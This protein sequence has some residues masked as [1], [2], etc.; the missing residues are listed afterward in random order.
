MPSSVGTRRGQTT[1]LVAAMV[2]VP[3]GHPR[4]SRADVG[5]GGG[6]AGFTCLPDTGVS[7]RPA[8]APQR[9][10]RRSPNDR[11]TTRWRHRGCRCRASICSRPRDCTRARS[12]DEFI[13]DAA[14]RLDSAISVTDRNVVP[15]RGTTVNRRARPRR[16]RRP[17]RG[18][19]HRSAAARGGQRRPAAKRATGTDAVGVHPVAARR[20]DV[21]VARAMAARGGAPGAVTSAPRLRAL[22]T[23]DDGRLRDEAALLLLRDARLAALHPRVGVPR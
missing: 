8:A 4:Q 13:A 23:T 15:K 19:A 17:Q 9:P 18:D 12:L 11:W 2:L 7:Q 1:W 14:R 6:R 22:D 3:P 20:N 5:S 16:H 21:A 10:D